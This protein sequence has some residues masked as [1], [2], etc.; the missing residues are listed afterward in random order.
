MK[1]QSGIIYKADTEKNKKSIEKVHS[2]NIFN[3]KNPHQTNITKS[4]INIFSNFVP[5]I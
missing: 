2:E 4:I 5:D 3:H 1:V